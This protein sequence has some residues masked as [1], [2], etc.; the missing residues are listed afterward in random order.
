MRPRRD[1][2]A[3]SDPD[4]VRGEVDRQELRFEEL[5][6][7]LWR[8]KMRVEREYNAWHLLAPGSQGPIGPRLLDIALDELLYD[9]AH[10]WPVVMPGCC[11]RE[12]MLVRDGL[13]LT[14]I[15]SSRHKP[16]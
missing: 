4:T 7:C 5:T 13:P 6:R 16:E 2:S 3:G 8:E 9:E 15:R 14:E 11:Q 1:T 12:R 10:N